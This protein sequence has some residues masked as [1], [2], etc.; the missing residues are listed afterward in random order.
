MSQILAKTQGVA[1]KLILSVAGWLTSGLRVLHFF[2][3]SLFFFVFSPVYFYEQ[4][5]VKKKPLG[6]FSK[7]SN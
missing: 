6:L 5:D 3:C 7:L 2:S 1:L 4:V